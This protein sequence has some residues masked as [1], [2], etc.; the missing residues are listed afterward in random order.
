[1]RVLLE[2]QL[3]RRIEHV[4][5]YIE[6]NRS[7]NVGELARLVNLSTLTWAVSSKTR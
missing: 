5:K 1:M 7:A 4:L 3:D 6:K 2:C